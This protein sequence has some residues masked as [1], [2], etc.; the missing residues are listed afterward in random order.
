MSGKRRGGFGDLPVTT[1]CI[2]GDGICD[3]PDLLHD[4]FGAIASFIGYFTRHGYYP[5]R[6][7]APVTNQNVWLCDQ[8][9]P[10]DVSTTSFDCFIDAPSTVSDVR[11][12]IVNEL[13][14]LVGF[15]RATSST[16][17]VS[18]RAPTT[19]CPA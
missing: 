18:S 17:G 14:S 5:F 15:R 4:P 9:P 3:V 1:Y 12:Q 7:Y 11:K 8:P 16:S 2:A 6:M 13:R 19:F 10:E